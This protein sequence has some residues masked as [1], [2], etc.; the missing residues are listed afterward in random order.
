MQKTHPR[1]QWAITEERK[2]VGEGKRG[3]LGGRR[4]IK[5]KKKSM[6]FTNAATNRYT[7]DDVT[8]LLNKNQVVLDQRM[9]PTNYN[10]RM[11]LHVDVCAFHAGSFMCH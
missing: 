7:S 5:K 4:I 10:V 2:S 3:D 11:V 9:A 8:E 6:I 1:V